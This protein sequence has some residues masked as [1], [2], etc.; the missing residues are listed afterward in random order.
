MN[1]HGDLGFVFD[2]KKNFSIVGALFN[3][4]I[5]GESNNA[6]FRED[7]SGYLLSTMTGNSGGVGPVLRKHGLDPTNTL[8][9]TA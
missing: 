2:W 1:K 4:P 8:H 5:F 6:S 3:Q 7:E 9:N